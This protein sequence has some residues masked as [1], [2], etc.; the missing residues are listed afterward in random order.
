VLPLLFIFFEE[1]IELVDLGLHCEI[2]FSLDLLSL[3]GMELGDFLQKSISFSLQLFDISQQLI[4]SLVSTHPFDLNLEFVIFSSEVSY[5]REML[6]Y[7][8][9]Q[10]VDLLMERIQLFIKFRNFCFEV[11]FFNFRLMG[12]NFLWFLLRL[13][14][15]YPSS[16]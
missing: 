3:K 12:L 8:C 1:G 9:L 5:G 6:A 13:L 7:L 2:D 10:K 4:I 16:P 15:F 11:V 14:S